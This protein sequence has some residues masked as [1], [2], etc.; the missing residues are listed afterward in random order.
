MKEKIQDIKKI[1][2]KIYLFSK[3][4][5]LAL[6]QND[7]HVLLKYLIKE[8]MLYFLIAFLFF[9]LVFFVN[10]ILLVAQDI[11]KKHVPVIDVIK[12]ITY[13]LP[14]IIA[15]SA[16]FGT[17]VGFLMCIG[18]LMS[19]NE[20]LIL[21]ATGTSFFSLSIPVIVLGVIISLFSFFVNDYL[22][23]LGTLAYSKL[24]K[25]IIISNPAVEIES[26]SIKRT[27]NSILVIGEVKDKNISDLLLFDTD[28][29]GN[30]RL[31]VSGNTDIVDS[32]D[33]SIMLQFNMNEPSVI[34]FQN[35]DKETYD[36]IKAKSS[37]MNLFM[38]NF[39]ISDSSG[40]NPREMTSFDLKRLIDNMKKDEE[41]SK[42]KINIYELEYNK[43]FSLPFGSLF[44]SLLAFPLAII[45]GKNNGQTIGLIIGILISV[46]YWAFMMLGQVFGLRNG[47]NGF[48]SMWLPNFIVGV[49]GIIFFLLLVKK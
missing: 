22:L 34:Q 30:Q 40:N 35:S 12:L 42:S 45:F 43:K 32:K 21:R 44:F 33:S 18:R 8:L 23:P 2:A 24:Y 11:L 16:P 47:F 29:N 41:V 9:F 14:F 4:A 48:I 1:F 27:N 3:D 17:L 13:S 39:S 10:Q 31:I 28:S 37:T 46:L 19:D 7:K 36:Y 25:S 26:N 15:Q 49:F 6:F 5:K 20:I 38:N